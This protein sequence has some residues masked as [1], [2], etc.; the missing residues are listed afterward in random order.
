MENHDKWQFQQPGTTWK[1]AGLYHLTLTVTDRQPLLGTLVIPGDNPAKAVVRRTPLGNALV[2]CLLSVSSLRRE[3]QV[4][5]FCLM[6]DHLHAILYVH[7]AMP[8][9]IMTA[10]RGFWQSTKKLGRAASFL[11]QQP[12]SPSS[13]P[14]PCSLPSLC[15]SSVSG[16][17]IAAIPLEGSSSLCS[18]SVSDDAIAANLQEETR[19][20]QLLASSLRR[21]LGTEAYYSLPPIFTEMPFVRPMS[22]R[23]QLPATIRYIDMN[24][25]RLATKRL[26]P[27][28]FRVQKGIE[29]AGRTYE[30]VGNTA[31]LMSG[32]FEPVH[33]RRA[34]VEAANRGAN[35]SLRD[36]MNSRILLARQGVVMVSPFISPQE[37]QVMQ[38]LLK[39]RHPFIC[40]LD[41]GFRDYY[42]PSDT[43]FDACA[44][45]R[46]L[47][48]SPWQYD[49]GKRH[50]SRADCVALNTMAEEIALA[51]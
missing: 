18:S 12:S 34:M 15:S 45:G 25:Q 6:P 37:K 14:S 22:R 36:Y 31:L 7:H 27:G 13:S 40:L 51:Q 3:I 29:I 4:L 39:E 8:T 5:H 26:K 49:S 47:F 2:E 19:Q 30:G 35:K 42:K 33:V 23:S 38:V 44:E 17:A 9:G 10:V 11:R 24:P 32:R 28:L 48:L 46:L 50:I 20:F 1:G 41:N 21:Q 43:L 16:D